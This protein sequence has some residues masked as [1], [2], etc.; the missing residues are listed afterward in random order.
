MAIKSFLAVDMGA[1]SG[2]HV[3]GKFD[4]K[5]LDLEEIYRFNNGPIQM[6]NSYF[7]NLPGLWS[8]VLEGLKKAGSCYQKSIQSIGVDTW[9]V[10]FAFLT[11]KGEILGNPYCYRDSRTDGAMDRAFAK[12]SRSDIFDKTGLQFMQ[13]NSLYQLFVMREANSPL[14]DIADRF[15]MIPDIFHW[16]LSGVP[17]N[18]FTDSTTTQC[19][20]PQ[21]NDW[22]WDLLKRFDIPVGL[23]RSVSAPGTILGGLLP[24]IQESTGLTSTKVVLPGSH[25]TASAVMSVPSSS[26][27]G[28]TDWAY[29]S[30]GTWALMGVESAQPYVNETV[31]KLNFTNEGGVGGT[32]RVLKNICGLWLIQEC[33][34]NWNEQRKNATPLDWE[35][36][37]KWAASAKQLVSFIDP[38]ARDFLGPTNMP[39]AIRSY[40]ERTGQQVPS[41]E[42]EILRVALDSIAMKFRQTLEKCEEITN[43]KIKTIHIVG[44][45]TKNRLLCQA[46]ADATNCRVVTG[47]VEATAIGNIMMQAV[48]S[49][50]VA[51]IV[52]ARQIIRNSFEVE[53][54]LPKEAAKWEDAFPRFRAIVQQ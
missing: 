7:W 5:K 19:F 53:E 26:P 35:D 29:I 4:G 48:A 45:G 25:D 10:D 32:T 37:N 30:L 28:M 44:G 18:E 33:R 49:G 39:E 22:A 11:K 50:E 24:S 52:E 9:G 15:L 40:T 54:Y 23:F 2:R 36:L 12:V 14:F 20:D 38:D 31:A 42:G 41:T 1:S 47:P 8:D 13:F 46:A 51:N 27:V 3:L 17:S 43:Q 6:M 16:L 34:R 21:K